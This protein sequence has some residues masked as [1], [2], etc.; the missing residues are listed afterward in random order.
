MENKTIRSLQA[1]RG[2]AALLVVFYHY[3][4]MAGLENSSGVLGALLNAGGIGVTIFFILSG[5]IMI[6]SSEGKSSAL[7]F[8][9][10]R[11]S[12][13]YPAYL[14]FILISF[15]VSGAMSTFHY[16]SKTISFLTSFV[17][18]PYEMINIPAYIDFSGASG[19]RWT[20]NYEMFFYA[21]MAL[22]MLFKNKNT[23]LFLMFFMLLVIIPILS[24]FHPTLGIYGYQY[25]NVMMAFITNPIMYQFLLGVVVALT[26]KQADKAP[27]SLKALALIF[28]VFIVGYYCFYKG[29]NNH[30][31]LSSGGY[32]LLFFY[33][34]IINR[35][36]LDK[37]TPGFLVYLGEISFSV[38]LFHN[39]VRYLIEKYAFKNEV[40]L[41]IALISI[42]CT[43]CFSV[44]THK[45]LEVAVSR[46]LKKWLLTKLQPVKARDASV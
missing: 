11:F 6:Y 33:S 37:L 42:F 30:G 25:E 3:K 14:F 28:S 13:I 23:A 21:L 46:K 29:Y 7:E 19:V 31:L 17:F 20:L 1:I 36:W 26:Y 10:S 12:R 41:Y 38:Y 27:A 9:I 5:F 34:V 8:A 45:Y 43:L 2:V 44:F 18:L 32:L 22:S 4:T 15:A 24:G 40:G 16:E 39:P 35:H